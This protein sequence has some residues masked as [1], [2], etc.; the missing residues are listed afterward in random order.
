MEVLSYEEW[1][2][3]GNALFGK[4]KKDWKFVCPQCKTVQSFN[5]LIEAGVSNE[6]AQGV[7]AFSCIGRYNNKEKGCNWTLGGL[8][9]IHELE[10]EIEGHKRPTFEF[11]KEENV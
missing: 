4:N 9:R 5:D 10:I 8:F 11:L 7:I 1:E 2:K 3:Q 6:D